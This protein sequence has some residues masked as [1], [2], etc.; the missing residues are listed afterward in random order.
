[1]CVQCRY[2]Q[3]RLGS[4]NNR[5][6]YWKITHLHFTFF[7][8]LI[9]V[10][11]EIISPMRW[12]QIKIGDEQKKIKQNNQFFFCLWKLIQCIVVSHLFIIIEP[13]ALI[14]QVNLMMT[15]C[16]VLIPIS[17]DTDKYSE[18]CICPFLWHDTA[19]NSKNTCSYMAFISREFPW[20][21]KWEKR[22]YCCANCF[23]LLSYHWFDFIIFDFLCLSS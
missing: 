22:F 1:M 23:W 14:L 20:K 7:I 3:L 19:K 5:I 17:W 10:Q 15:Y 21:M 2:T 8:W 9:L 11:K 4:L 12:D 13:S 16:P 18:N 6:Q